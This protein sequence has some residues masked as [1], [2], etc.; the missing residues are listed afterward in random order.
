MGVS[1]GIDSQILIYDLK[2]LTIRHRVTPTQYGGFAKVLFSTMK[3]K[4]KQEGE[5]AILLYAAS[6]LGDFFVI[7]VRSG[8]VV[9]IYKGHAAPINEFVEVRGRKWIVTAGDDNQCNIFQLN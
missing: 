9:Q 3:L 1:A 6:T 7:D 2:G 8:E 4:T 5:Q